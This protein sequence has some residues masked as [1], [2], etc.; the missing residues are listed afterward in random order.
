M[1]L[2]ACHFRT[3]LLATMLWFVHAA[4]SSCAQE[5]PGFGV[6]DGA[7]AIPGFGEYAEFKRQ[8]RQRDYEN[9]TRTMGRMDVDRNGALEEAE[10]RRAGWNQASIELNDLNKDGRVT[11]EELL[12]RNVINRTGGDRPDNERLRTN[13]RINR[14][15]PQASP[16][17]RTPDPDLQARRSLA[18]QVAGDLVAAY[19]KNNTKAIEPAEWRTNS[20]YG[21]IGGADLNGD[22]VVERSELGSWLLSRLPS[23]TT[24][25]LA[26]LFRARDSNGDGQVTQSEYAPGRDP[27]QIAEFR[28]F[29]HN[30]DGLVTPA[31][32]RRPAATDSTELVNRQEFIVQPQTIVVSEIWIEDDFVVGDVDVRIVFTKRGDYS[33]SFILIGPDGTRVVL[34]DNPRAQPWN[35]GPL[36]ENTLI[37]D[38]APAV[39]GTLPRPPAIKTFRPQSLGRDGGRGLASFDGQSSRGRWRLAARNH[40]RS[41]TAYL[42]RW[43]LVVEPQSEAKR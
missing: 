15:T 43:S 37:D 27:A 34:Y 35:G 41:A 28:R 2:S 29:D 12:V 10:F 17:R 39:K 5:I 11:L 19:D 31:E 18:F 21:N 33:T 36:F 42:H 8:L 4:A 22:N 20:R 1:H 30:G 26:A 9:A 25:R 3:L 14:S 23:V 16:P 32:S 24:S 13:R 6:P 7:S 40:G 38:E